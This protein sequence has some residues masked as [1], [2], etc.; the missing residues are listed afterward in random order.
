MQMK[1]MDEVKKIKKKNQNKEAEY[2]A[3]KAK[4]RKSRWR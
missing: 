3:K 1:K 4:H 2:D